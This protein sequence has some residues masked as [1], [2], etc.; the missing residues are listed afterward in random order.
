MNFCILI[1]L[2]HIILIFPDL[3]HY[4]RES[5]F[6][7]KTYI[8]FSFFHF[9][10]LYFIW[11]GNCLWYNLFQLEIDGGFDHIKFFLLMDLLAQNWNLITVLFLQLSYTKEWF[12]VLNVDNTTPYDLVFFIHP[13][14]YI[15]YHGFFSLLCVS[16]HMNRAY[17]NM[18]NI[19]LVFFFFVWHK[20][21]WPRAM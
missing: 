10:S 11:S 6:K 13:M 4:A 20:F 9:F 14:N 12:N 7:L 17:N 5:F 8:F 2:F 15:L 1:F 3:L 16:T 19:E 18:A 21:L